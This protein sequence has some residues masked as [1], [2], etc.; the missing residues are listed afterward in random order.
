MADAALIPDRHRLFGSI[1]EATEVAHSVTDPA[2][3]RGSV[4]A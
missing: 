1:T 4:G 3:R 2:R